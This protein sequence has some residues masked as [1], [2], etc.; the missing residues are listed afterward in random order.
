MS[1]HA[2]RCR[3]AADGQ[4]TLAW[5]RR[6]GQVL[7]RF[8]AASVPL[9]DLCGAGEHSVLT[10]PPQAFRPEPAMTTTR[11]QRIAA[12]TLSLCTTLAIVSG[13]ATLAAPHP[14]GQLLAGTAIG[15]RA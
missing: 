6:P 15:A 10:R 3:L 1:L 14:A 2:R 7:G 12:F 13:V 5:L 11:F 8:G 9:Q 4:K